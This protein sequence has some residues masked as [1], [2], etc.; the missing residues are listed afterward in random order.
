MPY[1]VPTTAKR[2]LK[3]CTQMIDWYIPLYFHDAI[4]LARDQT[5]AAPAAT[6]TKLT[7]KAKYPTGAPRATA[8]PAGAEAEGEPEDA[9]AVGV[10]LALPEGEV[11]VRLQAGSETLAEVEIVKSAH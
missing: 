2:P 7:S 10:P 6:P 1:F 8:P 5:I 11:V 9:G 4:L 3:H